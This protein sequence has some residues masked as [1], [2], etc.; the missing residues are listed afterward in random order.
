LRVHQ[1]EDKLGGNYSTFTW[2]I[3]CDNWY[4]KFRVVSIGKFFVQIGG[5]ELY[6]NLISKRFYSEAKEPRISPNKE[7]KTII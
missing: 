4:S 6:G 5:I 1:N 2:E 3:H 7:N